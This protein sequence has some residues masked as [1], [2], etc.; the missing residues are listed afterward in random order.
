MAPGFRL[1]PGAPSGPRLRRTNSRSRVR[2]ARSRAPGWRC[3]GRW[4]QFEFFPNVFAG[5]RGAVEIL[6]A[7]IV[8]EIVLVRVEVHVR[9]L[10]EGRGF[11]LTGVRA[12]GRSPRTPPAQPAAR[13]ASLPSL[14]ACSPHPSLG[15]G[16]TRPWISV[17]REA[18]HSARTRLTGSE[19]KANF[20]STARS[21]ALRARWG[22]A[23]A[24]DAQQAAC[25][26][27]AAARSLTSLQLFPDLERTGSPRARGSRAARTLAHARHRARAP[28]SCSPSC[29]RTA[30][31]TLLE[32]ARE[33][34]FA[35]ALFPAALYL[36]AR[37]RLWD[38][39]RILRDEPRP[40][41]A[42]SRQ[43]TGGGGGVS[44]SSFLA[45]P[46]RGTQFSVL[47]KVIARWGAQGKQLADSA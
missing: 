2:D 26:R 35:G 15:S 44:T 8:V 7:V 10:R 27:P 39:R 47:P 41:P 34:E 32:S 28:R 3:G 14:P 18:A 6:P 1:V 29:S 13:L 20:A 21:A 42:P 4:H 45:A 19:F 46:C 11:V 5:R 37:P 24:R 25:T 40:D 12:Q 30:A 31:L 38:W 43:P 9:S 16:E 22:R 36:V 23:G 17:P 33:R